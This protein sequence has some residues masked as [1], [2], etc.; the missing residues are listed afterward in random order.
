MLCLRCCCR[1]DIGTDN[2]MGNV[3]ACSKGSLIDP[4]FMIH[5]L[6]RVFW[7]L[8]TF[9]LTPSSRHTHP[10]GYDVDVGISTHTLSNQSYGQLL[11]ATATSTYIRQRYT[12]R[13]S[14]TKATGLR[15]SI[16]DHGVKKKHCFLSLALKTS[17]KAVYD[18]VTYMKRL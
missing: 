4:R 10:R 14:V 7:R 9:H 15:L 3:R 18:P 8:R 6:R 16:V 2:G 5:A 12:A 1:A 17:R 13:N 11:H